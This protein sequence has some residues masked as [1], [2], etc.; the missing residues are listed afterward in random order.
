VIDVSD[1]SRKDEVVVKR[2][3]VFEPGSIVQPMDFD[4]EVRRALVRALAK[5]IYRSMVRDNGALIQTK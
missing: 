3:V 5:A 4:P 2:D 1:Q